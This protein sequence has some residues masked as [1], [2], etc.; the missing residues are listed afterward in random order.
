M[1]TLKILHATV[2]KMQE[3]TCIKSNHFYRHITTARVPW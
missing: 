3:M 2:Y 1:K